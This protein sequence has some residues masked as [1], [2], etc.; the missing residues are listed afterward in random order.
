M[1][2]DAPVMAWRQW[3]AYLAVVFAGLIAYALCP[4][5]GWA[6]SFCDMAIGWTAAGAMVLG[7]RRHHP[8]GAAGWYLLASGVFLNSTGIMVETVDTRLLDMLDSPAP[9]DVFYLGLYPGLIGGLVL[10]MRRRT[11]GRDW[12][13]LVDALTITTGLGLLAWVFVI[14]PAV[15]DPQLSTLGQFIGIMYP[16]G[17]I[18]VLAI[19]ARLMLGGGNRTPAY[20]ILSAAAATFLVG[21]GIWVVINQVGLDISPFTEKALSMIFLGGFILF[22]LAALH[23]SMRDVA[24]PG[25]KRSQQLSRGLLALLSLVSLMAPGVLLLEVTSHNVEDGIAIAAGSAGLFLLVVTRM[26]QLLRQVER[27]SVRLRELSHVDELTGLPNRRAWTIE[28]PRAIEHARRDG[29]PLSVA[30][31][32][33]D[34]FKRFNDEYGHPAGDR[35]L[36]SAG[37]AWRSRLRVVDQLARYGGEEFIVLL[38]DAD[39]AAAGMVLDRLREV[40]PLGQTFSAGIACWDGTETSDELI[41]RADNALYAAKGAGRNRILL[42][43]AAAGAV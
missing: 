39:P 15:G 10:L 29:K 34:H 43:P 7:V 23:P 8:A 14:R 16:V 19:I 17:D 21:D 33:L 38:P 6:S 20:W 31:I 32:D 2:A 3:R 13:S 18:A 30:M 5:G 4:A 36:K 28:L 22:G 1:S 37:A 9:A 27:Q 11:T 26:A 24:Q 41:V 12:A 40:T 42:A 35:M 25:P